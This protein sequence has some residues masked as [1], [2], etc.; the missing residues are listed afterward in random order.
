[1]RVRYDA[2]QMAST[3]GRNQDIPM[4]G[5]FVHEHE[6]V[7][8]KT[9]PEQKKGSGAIFGST[10]AEIAPEPFSRGS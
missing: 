2:E 1:M 4:Q 6:R 8:S 5:L 3:F 9:V 7:L 10:R